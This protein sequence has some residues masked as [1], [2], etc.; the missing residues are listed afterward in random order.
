MSEVRGVRGAG[1]WRSSSF[2]PEQR[3]QRTLIGNK[4]QEV[5]I[6]RIIFK[7]VFREVAACSHLSQTLC[8][9]LLQLQ[10][11]LP[12]PKIGTEDE[13]VFVRREQALEWPRARSLCSAPSATTSVGPTK[14]RMMSGRQQQG[15]VLDPDGRTGCSAY[16]LEVALCRKNAMQRV[17]DVGSKRCGNPGAT[18]DFARCR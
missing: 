14:C 11:L 1:L 4:T 3:R 8:E 9:L 2:G 7:I 17:V 13:G 15:G 6:Y 16:A 12:K 5:R 18:Q 10:L